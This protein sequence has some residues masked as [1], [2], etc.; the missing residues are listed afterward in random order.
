V[1]VPAD[2]GS[3]DLKRLIKKEVLPL[4]VRVRSLCKEILDREQQLS[5]DLEIVARAISRLH[6][7]DR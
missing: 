5:R 1:F 6:S 7:S 4:I 2:A 3:G